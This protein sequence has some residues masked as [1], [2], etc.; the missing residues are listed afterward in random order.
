MKKNPLDELAWWQLMLVPVFIFG[1]IYGIRYLLSWF[2][3]PDDQDLVTNALKGYIL[4][5]GFTVSIIGAFLEGLLLVGWYFPGSFIIFLTVILAGSVENTIISVVVVTLGMYSAY[6][7]NYL[8][9]KYGWYKVLAKFGLEGAII[10]SAEKLKT[11]GTR[12]IFMTF[13]QP[14]L[15]SFTATA[16]GVIQYPFPRFLIEAAVSVCIWNAFWGT[17]AYFVGEQILKML[18]NWY[19]IGVMLVGWLGLQ[20]YERRKKR[21]SEDVPVTKS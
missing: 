6:V 8:L 21:K 4:Q 14:G 16:A 3:L 19:F 1:L 11:Y 2:G 17:V 5:Y 12:A 18:F 9:G 7:V 13:W 15:A 10:E 20:F